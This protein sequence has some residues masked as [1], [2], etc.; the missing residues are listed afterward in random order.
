MK[1][2]RQIASGLKADGTVYLPYR[3]KIRKAPDHALALIGGGKDGRPEEFSW[4]RPIS[5]D[6]RNES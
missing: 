3:V 6:L 2:D 5:H 1:I 4:L